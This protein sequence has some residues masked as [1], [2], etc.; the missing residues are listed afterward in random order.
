MFTH[1]SLKMRPQVD[2][3]HRLTDFP[4][5]YLA[6]IVSHMIDRH[7]DNVLVIALGCVNYTIDWQTY[8]CVPGLRAGYVMEATNLT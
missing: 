5:Y 1:Y 4:M 6:A 7:C 2:Q 3:P 8:T